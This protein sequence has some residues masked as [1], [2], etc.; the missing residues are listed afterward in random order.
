MITA[1]G[2]KYYEDNEHRRGF[3]K[4]FK[5]LEQLLSFIQHDALGKERVHLPAQNDDGTFDQRYA[6]CFSGTLYYVSGIRPNTAHISTHINLITDE[7][8]RKILFSSGSST[9]GKGHI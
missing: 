3:E 7:D 6:C 2:F 9:G 4:K 8:T 1:K 5:N